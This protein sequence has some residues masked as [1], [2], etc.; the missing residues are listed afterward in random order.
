[1]LIEYITTGSRRK[2]TRGLIFAAL[3]LSLTGCAL[4]P[5]GGAAVSLVSGT[6]TGVSD[7]TS[8][9]VSSAVDGTGSD[10]TDTTPLDSNP[11]P[12]R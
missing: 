8:N 9:V 12:T 3:A 6:M 5:V 10:T 1:M 11:E 7:I 4:G 2:F